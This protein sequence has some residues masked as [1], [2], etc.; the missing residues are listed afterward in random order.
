[1]KA[2]STIPVC[3]LG[4]EPV[5]GQSLGKVS[6]LRLDQVDTLAPGNKAFKL[7]AFLQRARQQGVTRVLSF[8]GPWSNHLHALAA[9]GAE[10]GLQTVGIVRGGEFDTAM[11]QDARQWG[12]EL[13]PV[14]RAEFRQR[15]DVDYQQQLIQ[16]H[17]PCLLIP[18]GGASAEGVDGCREIASVVNKL[19]QHWRAVILPVGTGTTLAGLGLDLVCA[20]ELLGVSAL[21]G[22]MDL[23]Q[24]VQTMLGE[25]GGASSVPWKILHDYHCGGFA[26]CDEALQT[27]ITE[28]ERVH[29]LPLEPVYT[30]KM[31][32]AIASLLAE[33]RWSEDDPILAIHTGGLQGRRGFAWLS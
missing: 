9:V 1:M 22:A 19:G 23:D 17:A 16:R 25:A 7:R 6:V 32:Y 8:G 30:G 5:G 15:S 14:S 21:R 10:L 20:D 3:A 4:P 13:V 26:R 2:I 31:F 24:R 28:F 12:M 27:F 18:E 33:G 11:L 29:R